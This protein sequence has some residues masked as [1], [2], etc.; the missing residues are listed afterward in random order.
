MHVAYVHHQLLDEDKLLEKA[1]ALS[2]KIPHKVL[3]FIDAS[4][5]YKGQH[6]SLELALARVGTSENLIVNH[7]DDIYLSINYLTVLLKQLE[8]KGAGLICVEDNLDFG[9]PLNDLTMQVLS[10]LPVGRLYNS[11]LTVLQV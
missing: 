3:T 9:V 11:S 7:L 8:Q 4:Y 6:N 5:D 10:T 1:A 2:A